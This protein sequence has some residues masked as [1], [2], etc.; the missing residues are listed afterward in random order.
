MLFVSISVICAQS[1]IVSNSDFEQIDT[2]AIMYGKFHSN[3]NWS[4][5]G[6]ADYYKKKCHTSNFSVPH[7]FVGN[8]EPYSG[9]SYIGFCFMYSYYNQREYVYT[10]LISPLEKDKIYT[11]TFYVSL[12]DYS[13]Y[14]VDRIG[15][16]FSKDSLEKK[17]VH[18]KYPEKKH[19]HPG[20]Y[21][22]NPKD[23][24]TIV[25]PLMK[26]DS[27]NWIK[28][29]AQYKAK[30]GEEY[31]TLGIFGTM[32]SMKEY[33]HITSNIEQLNVNTFAY[34]YIDDVQVVEFVNDNDL[35]LSNSTRV[36]KRKNK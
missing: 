7:N 31:M 21:I 2:C 19:V 1:N 15:V 13:R 35:K 25:A 30:G 36:A 10:R 27:I 22:L 20:M 11:V 32:I 8:Q 6:T 23:Y 17:Y 18:K 34:Y 24:I 3:S 4:C 26:S 5:L 33:K 29:E 12:A 9:E 14:S 28:L 16:G